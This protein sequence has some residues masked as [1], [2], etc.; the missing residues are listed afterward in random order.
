[1]S[2]I[3]WETPPAAKGAQ[4]H[5]W[6]AI[7]AQLAAAPGRWALVA[8]CANGTVANSTA[9]NIRRGKYE[10]LMALGRFEAKSRTVDGEHR[11]YA[12]YVGGD[13]SQT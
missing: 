8:V 13:G 6:A 1:M 7:G 3:R 12:R 4:V 5:D 11:V 2:V 10:P 9:Y